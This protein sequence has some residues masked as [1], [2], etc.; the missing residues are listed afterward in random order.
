LKGV[1]LALSRGWL[2]PENVRLVFLGCGYY[3]GS[4]R[5]RAQL[6]R[7][8]LETVSEVITTRVPYQEALRRQA[9]A[10]AVV[11]LQDDVQLLAQKR[12]W[13]F[14][15]VPAKLYEYLRLGSTMLVIATGEAIVEL[16]RDV[17]APPA[18]A[19]GDVEGIAS[20]LRDAFVRWQNPADTKALSPATERYERKKLTAEFAGVLNELTSVPSSR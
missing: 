16:L 8:G 20:A 1:E 10:G 19:P 5:F 3:G 14:M 17:G 13:T 15:L 2:S 11:V 12:D 7:Y 18:V 9:R 6:Q 4:D